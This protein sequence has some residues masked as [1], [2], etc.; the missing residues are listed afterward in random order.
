[1][2][3][4][5]LASNQ[6]FKDLEI[7]RKCQNSKGRSQNFVK[8]KS[9]SVIKRL[10][11]I[12]QIDPSYIKD[13]TVIEK[14][15]NFPKYLKLL[16]H[17]NDIEIYKFKFKRYLVQWGSQLVTKTRNKLN[18]DIIN[19]LEFLKK[20][21][22]YNSIAIAKEDIQSYLYIEF[23]FIKK[24]RQ[25]FLCLY[26]VIIIF[27]VSTLYQQ[28]F[29]KNF[30]R[31]SNLCF[32]KNILIYVYITNRLQ[33]IYLLSNFLFNGVFQYLKQQHQKF[34][35]FFFIFIKNY[36]KQQF[37]ICI[38]QFQKKIQVQII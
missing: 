27:Y 32:I 38:K 5:L 30:F 10:R 15:I 31:L 16:A 7:T 3:I 21:L 1:M 4:T 9:R 25:Q 19:A 37:I 24:I 8:G 33:L 20:N 12:K 14:N 18:S 22:Q 29:M 26:I 13:I 11:Y 17:Y 35:I 23:L 34:S 36:H 6:Y 2:N 28:F